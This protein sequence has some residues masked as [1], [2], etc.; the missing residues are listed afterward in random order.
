MN[1][2]DHEGINLKLRHSKC[3][4]NRIYIE[5]NLEL[6]HKILE[7]NSEALSILDDYDFS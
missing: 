7:L 5:K 2:Y 4:M 1:C 6:Y 3:I